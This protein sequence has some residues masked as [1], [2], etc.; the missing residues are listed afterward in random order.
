MHRDTAGADGAGRVV[1]GT[2]GLVVA[3]IAW[4]LAVG[5]APPGP[6][7]AEIA[8]HRVDLNVAGAEELALL[9]EVGPSVAAAIVADRRANGPFADV[10]ALSRVRGIGPAT[11]A[12]LSPYACVGG[13][14]VGEAASDER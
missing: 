9:P 13:V 3:A 12:A 5:G 10:G 6:R 7:P 4:S 14:P 11:V 2:L 8:R 1:A